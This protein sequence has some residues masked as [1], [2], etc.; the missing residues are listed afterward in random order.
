MKAATLMGL[1]VTLFAT[2]SFA[3]SLV[4]C[5]TTAKNPTSVL[6]YT[7]SSAP[8]QRLTS[9]IVSGS[10]STAVLIPT[11]RISQYKTSNIELYL[12]T[13]KAGGNLDLQFVALGL[14]GK[15]YVG[16]VTQYGANNKAVKSTVVKCSVSAL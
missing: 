14:N 6:E 11:D 9:D 1:F 12:L 7:I 16:A 15:S 4:R 10:G 3:D 5:V 2:K 13:D 8:S